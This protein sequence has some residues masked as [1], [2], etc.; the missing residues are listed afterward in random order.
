MHDKLQE[1]GCD[2]RVDVLDRPPY[3]R[4]VKLRTYE[5]IVFNELKTFIQIRDESKL[6]DWTNYDETI[7]IFY[8]WEHWNNHSFLN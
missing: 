3:M 7:A 1:E 4:I 8:R 6:K 5:M 2:G